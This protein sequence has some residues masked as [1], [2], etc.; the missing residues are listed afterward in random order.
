MKAAMS[1]QLVTL[2]QRFGTS[3]SESGRNLLTFMSLR[4]QM[5]DGHEWSMARTGRGYCSRPDEERGI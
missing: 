2:C 3:A 5:L 1:A 4:G